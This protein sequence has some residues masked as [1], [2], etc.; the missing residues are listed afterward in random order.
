M[1]V[2]SEMDTKCW[3]NSTGQAASLE[4]NKVMFRVGI[5]L[6]TESRTGERGVRGFFTKVQLLVSLFLPPVSP[7]SPTFS[8]NKGSDPKRHPSVFSRGA[9]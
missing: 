8:L 2:H 5:L 4:K 3:S 1:L 7:P 6:Q 9:A